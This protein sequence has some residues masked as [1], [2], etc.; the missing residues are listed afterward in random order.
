[1]EAITVR[2]VGTVRKH[3]YVLF[4]AGSRGPSGSIP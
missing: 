1:M 4:R 3:G 2:L